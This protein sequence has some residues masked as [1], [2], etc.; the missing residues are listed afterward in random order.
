MD[1]HSGQKGHAWNLSLSLAGQTQLMQF[2]ASYTLGETYVLQEITGTNTPSFFQWQSVETVNGRNDGVISLSDNHIQH[3][4]VSMVSFSIPLARKWAGTV[5]SLLYEGQSGTPYSYVVNQSM[6]SDN[7]LENNF[8]LAYIPTSAD[9]AEMKF[10]PYS[11]G[12]VTYDEDL[13]RKMLDAYIAGN[14][15]LRSRRGGF[16]ARNGARLPS[17][18]ILDLRVRQDFLWKQKKRSWR[19]SL[20]ADVNNLL[21]LMNHNWGLQYFMNSGNT[22]LYRFEGFDGGDLNTPRYRFTPLPENPYSIQPSTVPG[23]SARWSCQIGMRL[24]ME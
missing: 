3:R 2:T 10:Q 20:T 22:S 5:L 12:S 24:S 14:E 17:S 7:G 8:D 18:H 4:V 16:A 13:Q 15:Y 23:R 6:V 11:L 9:L 21:N 1:N 19:I